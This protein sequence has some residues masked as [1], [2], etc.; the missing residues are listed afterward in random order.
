[1]NE[2]QFLTEKLE[3]PIDVPFRVYE[4]LREEG[5]IEQHGAGEEYYLD[6]RAIALFKAVDKECP[7]LIIVFVMGGDNV[8]NSK[9]IIA[10][11]EEEYNELPEAPMMNLSIMRDA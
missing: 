10:M 1:M 6:G 5:K 2:K 11:S 4:S 3:C 7:N 8:D 9:E